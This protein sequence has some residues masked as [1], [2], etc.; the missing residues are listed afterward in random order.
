MRA[1][2]AGRPHPLAEAIA[3]A[4]VPGSGHPDIAGRVLEQAEHVLRYQPVPQIVKRLWGYMSQ[5]FDACDP[6]E[7]QQSA[8]RGNPPFSIPI[9]KRRLLPPPAERIKPIDLVGK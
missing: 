1:E 6:G 2:R 8:S 5:V 7:A 3:G 4:L 9:L